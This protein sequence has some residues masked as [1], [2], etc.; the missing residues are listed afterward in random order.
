MYITVANIA[1]SKGEQKSK[2]LFALGTVWKL[3]Q[4]ALPL[5]LC[6]TFSMYVFVVVLYLIQV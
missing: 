1:F 3:F 6:D 2:L 4:T 5:R